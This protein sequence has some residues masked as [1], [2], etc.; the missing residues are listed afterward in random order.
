[1]EDYQAEQMSEKNFSPNVAPSLSSGPPLIY[2][3]FTKG[4]IPK[5]NFGP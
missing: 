4:K 3:G 5:I 2:K 1:M